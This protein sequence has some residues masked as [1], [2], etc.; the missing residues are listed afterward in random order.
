M[1]ERCVIVALEVFR[2]ADDAVVGLHVAQ[3][4]RMSEP[5]RREENFAVHEALEFVGEV[6]ARQNPEAVVLVVELVQKLS[7]GDRLLVVQSEL[8]Y[9]V[10]VLG[11]RADAGVVDE[12]LDRFVERAERAE[13]VAV[14]DRSFPLRSE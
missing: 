2:Q 1:D 4:A 7:E 9:S 14:V 8:G 5:C 12:M 3:L 13:A 6:V 10:L 11:R